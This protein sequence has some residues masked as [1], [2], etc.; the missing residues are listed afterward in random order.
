M[1]GSKKNTTKILDTK[2]KHQKNW[3]IFIL[4]WWVKSKTSTLA[5]DL[6]QFRNWE[7]DIID[8]ILQPGSSSISLTW[9]F[10]RIISVFSLLF[11][12]KI[13]FSFV[14]STGLI[15]CILGT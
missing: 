5:E 3:N 10:L 15:A 4:F 6:K 12:T 1:P 9:K 8:L 14:K 13:L 11:K 2:K 7:N